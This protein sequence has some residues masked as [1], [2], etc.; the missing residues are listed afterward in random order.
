MVGAVAPSGVCPDVDEEPPVN[1]LLSPAQRNR[2][3]LLLNVLAGA[4][5]AATGAGTIAATAAAAAETAQDRAVKARETEAEAA[6]ARQEAL[7]KWAADNPVV[8]TTPRPV[9]TVVGPEVLVGASAA[10][11]ATVGG[12][13]SPA[14]SSGGV[15]TPPPPPAPPAKSTG[16]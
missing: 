16:S 2:S 9:R 1:P 7:A 13:P 5:A 11:S 3:R 10:G 14:G 8:V 15:N 4:L 6:R 12:R